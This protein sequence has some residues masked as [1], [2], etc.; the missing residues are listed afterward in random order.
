MREK[1]ARRLAGRRRTRFNLQDELI[2]IT[3]TLQTTVK[4]RGAS[5]KA[6]ATHHSTSPVT[7]HLPSVG[8]WPEGGTR[9][10]GEKITFFKMINKKKRLNKITGGE[11]WLR[12]VWTDH[13]SCRHLHVGE[14]VF[15]K[16]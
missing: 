13:C 15:T 10:T 7:Q 9:G 6:P 12:R 2:S 11:A 5:H 3:S 14:E 16:S 4:R 1:L 8:G